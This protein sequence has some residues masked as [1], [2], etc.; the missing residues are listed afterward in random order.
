MALNI[1]DEETDSLARRVAELSGQ[2][3]TRAVHSSLEARLAEL[4]RESE[5]EARRSFMLD[6]VHRAREARDVRLAIP[7]TATLL[8]EAPTA[9]PLQ[10]PEEMLGFDDAGLPT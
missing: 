7:T 9:G 3:I 4:L 5:V 2:S 1:K 6:V 8:T 10:T